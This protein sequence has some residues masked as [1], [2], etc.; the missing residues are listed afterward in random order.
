MRARSKRSR[1]RVRSA[2]SADPGGVPLVTPDPLGVGGPAE[3]LGDVVEEHAKPQRWNGGARP[4]PLRRCGGP[5]N[6]GD[7]GCPAEPPAGAQARESQRTAPASIPAAPARPP[8]RRAA[9]SARPPPVPR[10]GRPR[11]KPGATPTKRL[12]RPAQNP[13]A[14]QTAGRGECAARPP[15]TAGRVP[16]RSGSPAGKVLPTAEGIAQTL[17]G[18][19]SHGVDGKIA[20]GQIGRDGIHK[21][22][23]VGMAVVGVPSLG[24]KG[25][26][27][28][29]HPIEQHGHGA[30]RK[31]GGDHP[32][33]GK[34]GRCL[35][36][37]CAGADV[38]IGRAHTPQAVPHAAAYH[39][40]PA[41]NPGG[42]EAARRLLAGPG[43][44]EIDT[45]MCRPSSNRFLLCSGAVFHAEHGGCGKPAL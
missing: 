42:V 15:Q 2:I 12:H 7:A 10:A 31:P 17:F 24:P 43:G 9:F 26:D 28:V 25:G 3:R 21:R 38:P 29:S 32:F 35:L 19:I 30:V 39:G 13:A 8:C 16:P 36:G 27:F 23:L 14:R 45:D 34:A 41:S 5:W 37:P 44:M 22:H 11:L 18:V 1:R 4:R 40:V 20:A 6:S 33:G